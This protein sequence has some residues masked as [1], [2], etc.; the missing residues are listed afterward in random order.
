MEEIFDVDGNSLGKIPL[1]ARQM[2][3]LAVGEN[4]TVQYHT[5]QLLRHLVGERSGSFELGKNAAGQIVVVPDDVVALQR[6][7]KL[8]TDIKRT[9]ES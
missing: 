9:R 1:S 5:P 4:I 8:F 7:V 3:L 6:F 2:D